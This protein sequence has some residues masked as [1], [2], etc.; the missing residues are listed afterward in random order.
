MSSKKSWFYLALADGCIKDSDPGL[1]DL[2]TLK[3]CFHKK[4][5][6]TFLFENF[7]S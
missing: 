6:L 5:K 1:S 7:Q 2:K 3:T 4:V